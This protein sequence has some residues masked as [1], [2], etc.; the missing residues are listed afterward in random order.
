MALYS[1]KGAYPTQLPNRI[2]LANG[3]TKT[4]QSTFTQEEL[5]EA[6]WYEVDTPPVVN[7]PNK[8]VWD[9]QT[10]S[11][12]ER[13]PNVAETQFK[14]QEIRNEC[15]KRLLD[16]DYKVIKAVETGEPLDSIMV[17]YRQ[18]LRDLY[19][20]VN[21]IDP[22]TVQYPMLQYPDEEDTSATV[23]TP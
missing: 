10:R 21:N 9:G 12:S 22:W 14:W 4:D 16:T 20:N 15:E 17:Q 5:D 3:F 6:G 23:E 13:E 1:F 18:D 19:N 2:K 8:L 11:W 7:Y